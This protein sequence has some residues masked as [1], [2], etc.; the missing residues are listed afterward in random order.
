MGAAGDARADGR[1]FQIGVGIDGVAEG[2]DAPHIAGRIDPERHQCRR[3]GDFDGSGIDWG[4]SGRRRAVG[5]VMDDIGPV[6]ALQDH[7]LRCQVGLRRRRHSDDRHGGSF[8]VGVVPLAVAVIPAHLIAAQVGGLPSRAVVEHEASCFG[9]LERI[10]E[11]VVALGGH[12]RARPRR[13]RNGGGR[14][15]IMDIDAGAPIAGFLEMDDERHG[16]TLLGDPRPLSD[17]V[18]VDGRQGVAVNDLPDA[19]PRQEVVREAGRD[20]AG[21]IQSP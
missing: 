20:G 10:A 6:A 7:L 1:P 21:R 18:V 3:P 13:R 11:P 9:G 4:G 17:A 14:I 15:P 16:L 2:A 12:G 19:F 8:R 5:G